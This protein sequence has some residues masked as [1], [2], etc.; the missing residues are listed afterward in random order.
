MTAEMSAQTGPLSVPEAANMLAVSE[1]TVRRYCRDGTLSANME[2]ADGK[3]DYWAIDRE[4]CEQLSQARRASGAAVKPSEHDRR[5][6]LSG[7]EHFAE[8]VRS[9]LADQQRALAPAAEE[10]Q[11]RADADAERDHLLAQMSDRLREQP[12]L[13]ELISKLA[14]AR[15][16]LDHA[17]AEITELKE[18]L[19]LERGKTWWQ[20]LRTR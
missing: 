14:R 18:E 19:A 7:S 4:S 8:I 11:A 15:Q 9:L 12:Q 5:L 1:A 6:M 17:E 13:H 2:P 16:Q 3:Q 10:V 20:K